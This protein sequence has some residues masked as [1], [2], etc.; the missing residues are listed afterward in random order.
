M[1]RSPPCS[2]NSPKSIS[3]RSQKFGDEISTVGLIAPIKSGPLSIVGLKGPKRL[4]IDKLE[5]EPGGVVGVAGLMGAGVEELFAVL[6][7][8]AKPRSGCESAC[9]KDPLWG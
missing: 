2:V 7:G 3:E 5:I 1:T 9:K 8:L 6:F 4:L